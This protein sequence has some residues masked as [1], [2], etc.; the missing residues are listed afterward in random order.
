MIAGMPDVNKSTISIDF[1]ARISTGA[2]WPAGEGR[3]PLG[4]VIFLTAEDGIADTIRPRLEVAGADVNRVHIVTA[5]RENNKER[6]FDLTTD[7][8]RRKVG[9]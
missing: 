7:I 6:S 9:H 8:D 4:Y 5:A 2:L 1:A 3:A